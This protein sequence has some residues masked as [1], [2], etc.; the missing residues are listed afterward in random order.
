MKKLIFGAII[1]GTSMIFGQF[2]I[3]LLG[4]FGLMMTLIVLLSLCNLI[5]FIIGKHDKFKVQT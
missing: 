5:F 2:H 4:V 1:I 3:L